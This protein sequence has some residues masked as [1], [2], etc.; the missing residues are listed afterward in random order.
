MGRALLRKA[1]TAERSSFFHFNPLLKVN[2]QRFLKRKKPVE[3]DWL[4]LVAGKD[5]I[6]NYLEGYEL[7]VELWLF[8]NRNED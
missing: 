3:F 7:V 5:Q 6:S 8:M 2:F 1:Q 4:F